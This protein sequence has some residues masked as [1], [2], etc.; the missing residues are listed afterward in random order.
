MIEQFNELEEQE[1]SET[2]PDTQLPKD[3]IEHLEERK[4]HRK[5]VIQTTELVQKYFIS[6]S[7]SASGFFLARLLLLI[8]GGASLWLAAG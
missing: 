4:K 1:D 2:T 5:Q 6:W 3:L 8:N 7:L